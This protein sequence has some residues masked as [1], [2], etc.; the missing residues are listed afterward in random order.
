M[1]CSSS[2]FSSSQYSS[3]S[4]FSSNAPA[5]KAI[6]L[7]L[8]CGESSSTTTQ[9]SAP[10]ADPNEDSFQRERYRQIYKILLRQR[11]DFTAQN[12]QAYKPKYTTTF[13]EI[14]ADLAK[15]VVDFLSAI[16]EREEIIEEREEIEVPN[17]LMKDIPNIKREYSLFHAVRQLP[18]GYLERI[19]G[20]LHKEAPKPTFRLS[21]IYD[22][23]IDS[24]KRK[25]TEN[26]R[27]LLSETTI[28]KLK[29]N[30]RG[31][32]EQQ[33]FIDSLL[34]EEIGWHALKSVFK[35]DRDFLRYL[36]DKIKSKI[37]NVSDML[38][39]YLETIKTGKV[40]IKVLKGHI[41][42]ALEQIKKGL[43]GERIS[44]EEIFIAI[45]GSALV[46]GSRELVEQITKEFNINFK[47][48]N[49]WDVSHSFSFSGDSS[50]F[51]SKRFVS[52]LL[53]LVQDPFISQTL[54]IDMLEY[55]KQ[56][57]LDFE[58]GE[59]L[60]SFLEKAAANNYIEVIKH[61]MPYLKKFSNNI[62]ACLLN[63][64]L[65]IERVAILNN[66]F[67]LV[68][69]LREITQGAVLF[70]DW[71]NPFMNDYDRCNISL[72]VV[73]SAILSNNL[74]LVKLF[75]SKVTPFDLSLCKLSSYK[76]E[77]PLLLLATEKHYI[78][79]IRYLLQIG[80]D[81]NEFDDK[82]KFKV[83]P[84]DPAARWGDLELVKEF[85]KYGAKISETTFSNAMRSNNIALVRHFVQKGVFDVNDASSG[86]TPLEMA[87][88]KGALCIA[89]EFI[90]RY[91]GKIS[92]KLLHLAAQSG[93]VGLVEYL[94]QKG[95]SFDCLD[96][97]NGHYSNEILRYLKRQKR[98]RECRAF[99]SDHYKVIS[100]V[101]SMAIVFTVVAIKYYAN[102]DNV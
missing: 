91:K 13:T 72:S 94:I 47:E 81:V 56:N 80:V 74:R 96:L 45:L 8:F 57:G 53:I 1:S 5:D 6:V 87:V 26:I 41:D 98:L 11:F 75:L 102:R 60:I 10:S 22:C 99:F 44:E 46:S 38:K 17:F 21:D 42:S 7:S 4:V 71:Y 23:F 92:G 63:A 65:L 16:E 101:A 36:E 86:T 18:D 59:Y 77:K 43:V 68:R 84:I 12:S 25:K 34:I 55:S 95:A 50:S 48:Y 19:I 35:D 97:V 78:P 66:N 83:Y 15:Q 2:S 76:F 3:S 30:F 64:C 51:H 28:L 24:L 20:E 37:K 52:P 82:I 88:F 39:F 93:N 90:E 14:P 61:L 27:F 67:E 70:Q 49:N 54:I 85:E 79:I 32:E 89:K 31:E 62:N 33:S 69:F 58:S 9:I 73:T 29:E 40:E 100:A